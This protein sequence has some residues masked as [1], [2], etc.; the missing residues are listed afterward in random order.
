[1]TR[2]INDT[3]F[4]QKKVTKVFAEEL[5]QTL[6]NTQNGRGY[7]F[8][9]LTFDNK[10]GCEYRTDMH[11]PTFKRSQENTKYKLYVPINENECELMKS[12]LTGATKEQRIIYTTKKVH[13]Y[14]GGIWQQLDPLL[15]KIG[16]KNLKMLVSY[17]TETDI[18]AVDPKDNLKPMVQVALSNL[19]KVAYK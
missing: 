1:M 12:V 9:Y 19:I 18:F 17:Q 3:F 2:T 11:K 10:W 8:I 15:T 16:S 14:T 13:E 7:V 6:L 5:A 4:N